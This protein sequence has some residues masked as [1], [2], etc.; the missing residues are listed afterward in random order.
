MKRGLMLAAAVGIAGGLA[1]AMWPKPVA[2]DLAEVRR[3]PLRVTV[4]EEGKT[5][6]KD[7][8]T[9]SA[10]ITGKLLRQTLEAGDRVKKDVTTVAVIEP[11]A[12]P[13]LDVRAQRELEAQI[14][15]AK[16]AVAL[17]EAEVRAAQSELQFAQS[18]LTRARA[19]I[20][21]SA[22][23]ERALERAQIDVD[24]RTAALARAK[25]GLEVRK[26]ELESAQAR[27]TAPE[28][29]WRGEV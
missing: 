21:S 23:S 2:V 7:V 29:A 18:E 4:D 10:P 27:T 28:E 9:V 13:F 16:A 11:T 20:R 25:A 24:T 1:W 5:R 12:P 6:I 8:Y 3:G 19:L 17:A 14:E 26:R 15:A 22:I